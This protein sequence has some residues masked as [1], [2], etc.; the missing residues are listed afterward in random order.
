MGCGAALREK[1][2]VN[3]QGRPLDSL[4]KYHVFL[5]T[6]LP[7]IQVE[8]ITDGTSKEGPYGAK[9]IGEVSFVPVAPAICGAVNQA[10]KSEIGHLP[11]D[12]DRILSYLSKER[13][14]P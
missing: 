6:D 8:L 3:A 7:D 12:P 11:L 14:K 13:N 10:L 5:A 2:T 9:S 4:S 1:L